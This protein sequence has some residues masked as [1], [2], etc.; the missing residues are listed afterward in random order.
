M[1]LQT[2]ED[3]RNT[4][5]AL[6]NREL[7]SVILVVVFIGVFVLVPKLR[8]QV[9]S[10][11]V[12]LLQAFFVWKIQLLLLLYLGYAFVIVY[13]AWR[14]GAWD[15]SLLKDTL[16]VVF[17]VGLPMVFSAN[18]V[19]SGTKLVRD[20]VCDV[21]GVSALV[22]FYLSLGSLPLW[23]ELLLQPFLILL[24]SLAAMARFNPEHRP[25]EKLATI[26]LGI[27]GLSLVAY[28]TR[29]L[30]STWNA[31]MATDAVASFVLTVWLP[32]ALIPAVYVFA[33]IMHSENILTMLP[34]LN[35]RKKPKLRIRLACLWGLHFS[36]RLASEFTGRWRSQLALSA[37][38]REAIR[39]MRQF[40]RAVK[41]R[42]QALEAH[43]ERLEQMTGVDGVD[44]D[45]LRLDRREF[46]ET[47]KELTNLYFMQMGWH[48][49]R[50]GT[51]RPELLDLL[52]DMTEK[53][54]PREHGIQLAVRKDK[55][56][57]RAWRQTSG[58]WYFG[59][60]GTSTLEHQWQYD[61]PTA[62]AGFPSERAAG[63]FN[64]TIG[65]SSPE[66]MH[67]DEAPT[68]V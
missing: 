49:N 39:T 2:V 65:A 38:V 30:V 40:R 68:R 54:L 66:W 31:E 29:L 26:L 63:W 59:V 9:S 33:F 7:A 18:G 52:G 8:R 14:L 15:S 35:D 10:S 55:Q 46:Y 22:V 37:G 25:V 57:W 11:F 48:R 53:G 32:I 19:R 50:G 43:N 67:N 56:A 61:G 4:M 6:T 42:D 20:V 16:I 27:I 44:E 41:D 1:T 45:G 34:F 36:T 64:A 24:V 58:G 23:G 3:I 5:L 21:V 28:T 47:K 51:Y 62:P 60:G 17:F 12:N 13:L